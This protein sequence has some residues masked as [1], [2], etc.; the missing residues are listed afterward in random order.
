MP[1]YSQGK[2][3]K[4]ECNITNE[5]YYGSTTLRYLSSRI[6]CHRY[7]RKTTSVNIID[8]G[9]FNIKV[10]EEYPCNNRQELEARE[11]YYI[12]N[13]VCIN[14]I[15]PNR[16]MKEWREDNK[17]HIKEY[18]EANKDKIK[19]Y[20]K[21]YAEKNQEYIKQKHKE[22]REANKEKI[23][24]KITCECGCQIIKRNKQPHIKSKK[25]QNYL[26][27]LT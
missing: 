9:N 6:A 13:N 17:E 20:K 12:R 18:I 25:H 2:I 24:E 22:Y 14:K 10:I 21:E 3:Y 1:D 7:D 4:I 11:A 8:R 5:V 15:I 26:I 23:N 27:T 19:E 16:T